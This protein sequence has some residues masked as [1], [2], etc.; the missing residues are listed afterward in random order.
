M[1]KLKESPKQKM[2]RAFL[3]AITCG[4]ARRGES[5]QDTI[6]LMPVSCSSYYKH[7]RYPDMFTR[8]EL[9]VLVPRYFTDRELCE[10][11][12]VEYQA[13]AYG[14][15]VGK[16]SFQEYYD[17]LTGAGEMVAERLLAQAA[18][19]PGIGPFELRALVE[20]QEVRT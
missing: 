10:A 1:P 9:L 16:H 12:G 13:A 8:E 4:Q 18:Q 17:A 3:A 11:F 15:A 6:R 5:N 20:Y 7:L 2:D 14:G 19:D